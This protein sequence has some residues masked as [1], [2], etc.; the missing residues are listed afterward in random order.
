MAEMTIQLRIDPETGQKSLV[1]G[2]RS[3]ADAL[4]QEHEED[5]RKLVDRLVEGGALAAAERGAIVLQRQGD[6]AVQPAPAAEE[7]R[8]GQALEEG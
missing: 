7:P 2:Y 1:I 3:D 4:P 5:H 6:A 8:R